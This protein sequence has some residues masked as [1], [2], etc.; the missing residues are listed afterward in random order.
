MQNTDSEDSNKDGEHGIENDSQKH[1]EGCNKTDNE[2]ISC[3]DVKEQTTVQFTIRHQIV[4]YQQLRKKDKKLLTRKERMEIFNRSSL[5][6]NRRRKL[7]KCGPDGEIPSYKAKL[8]QERQ[9]HETVKIVLDEVFEKSMKKIERRDNK[10]MVASLLEDVLENAEIEAAKRAKER[11]GLEMANRI[12]DDILDIWESKIDANNLI[13]NEIDL[14]RFC[15]SIVHG[16]LIVAARDV[17]GVAPYYALHK[18]PLY[19]AIDDEKGTMTRKKKLMN[20]KDRQ[21]LRDKK[22]RALASRIGQN[23][24]R[25]EERKR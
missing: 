1:H 6:N 10:E 13:Q 8:E 23:N 2:L 19:K 22:Q 11:K 15:S 4:T 14:S 24:N 9:K 21:A 20:K 16:A 25:G 7:R 3:S 5:S 12:I 17:V 18:R